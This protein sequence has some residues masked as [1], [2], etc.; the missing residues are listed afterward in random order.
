MINTRIMPEGFIDC[1]RRGDKAF[2]GYLPAHK[3]GLSRKA[4]LTNDGVNVRV[5]DEY[6]GN[7]QGRVE[8]A[9]AK[10]GMSFIS[11]LRY[12]KNTTTFWNLVTILLLAGFQK[13]TGAGGCRGPTGR[14]V[15]KQYTSGACWKCVC[16]IGTHV[17]WQ[18][19]RC[20]EMFA[21]H[22]I[23]FLITLFN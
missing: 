11:G 3:V 21:Q 1:K 22:G 5:M 23:G 18:D 19:L 15:S 20:A 9:C 2:R 16:R 4:F 10:G 8:P 6:P 13:G 12:C 7:T 17:T 14:N